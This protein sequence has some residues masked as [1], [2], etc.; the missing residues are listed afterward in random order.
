MKRTTKSIFALIIVL[1][2][3]VSFCVPTFAEVAA[4]VDTGADGTGAVA[5]PGKGEQHKLSIL[6]LTA[7]TA[8]EY[9][10]RVVPAPCQGR[11][12]TIYKCPVCEDQFADNWV[13]G[14][15]AAH[16]YDEANAEKKDPDC[17]NDGY[18]KYTCKKCGD[19]V[20]EIK[21]ALGHDWS[22]W[23]AYID[24]VKVDSYLCTDKGVTLVREC[25]RP[26][27]DVT[28]SQTVT[29]NQE[30]DIV[31]EWVVYPTCQA[32]GTV[33]YTCANDGCQYEHVIDAFVDKDN[34]PADYHPDL[35]YD[36][37]AEGYIAPTCSTEGLAVNAY[38]KACGA[39]GDFKLPKVAHKW[40]P[41]EE[42]KPTCFEGGYKAHYD[43]EYCDALSLDGS[44][45]EK[46]EN[47]VLDA[48]NHKDKEKIDAESASNS[49]YPGVAPVMKDGTTY[50]PGTLVPMADAVVLK[51]E[52]KGWGMSVYYCKDCDTKYVEYIA[53]EENHPDMGEYIEE[54]SHTEWG[55]KG[56][57]CLECGY[58]DKDT[59]IMLPPY[60]HKVESIDKVPANMELINKVEP[61]C[62][63]KGTYTYECKICKADGVADRY[64][65]LEIP[66]LGHTYVETVVNPTCQKDGW[67]WMICSCGDV[68]KDVEGKNDLDIAT[69]KYNHK[70]KEEYMVEIDYDNLKVENEE[71]YKLLCAFHYTTNTE[72]VVLTAPTCTTKGWSRT[73]CEKCDWFCDRQDVPAL[74]HPQ[75]NWKNVQEIAA[76]CTNPGGTKWTCG[77]CNHNGFTKK[78]DPL[79]HNYYDNADNFDE[80]VGRYFKLDDEGNKV[81]LGYRVSVVAPTCT[82]G[83]YT[84][85][86]CGRCGDEAQFLPK[87]KLGHSWE[88]EDFVATKPDPSK[89]EYSYVEYP[90]CTYLDGAADGVKN[91]SW[92]YVCQNA[93]CPDK[94]T[95]KALK[96]VAITDKNDEDYDFDFHNPKHHPN[97]TNK[98][99]SGNVL[100]FKAP[101]CTTT[102]IEKYY[103]AD[104]HNRYGETS[105]E[106]DVTSGTFDVVVPKY[107]CEDHKINVV[108]RVEATCFAAGNY[109][110]FECEKCGTKY[111][112]DNAGTLVP[113][114]DAAVLVIPQR[115]HKYGREDNCKEDNPCIQPG[116]TYEK[117]ALAH[118]LTSVEAKE[119]TCTAIGWYAYSY[120]TKC[121]KTTYAERDKLAHTVVAGTPVLATCTEPG[122]TYFACTTCD[123][124]DYI[125]FYNPAKGHVYNEDPDQVIDATCT[126]DG[127]EI[128]HCTVCNPTGVD[129]AETDKIVVIPNKYNYVH[130]NADG[131]PFDFTCVN[132]IDDYFCVQCNATIAVTHGNEITIYDSVDCKEYIYEISMCSVCNLVTS[133]RTYQND[134]H[135]WGA[136]TQTVA[137]TLTSEGEEKRK[138]QIC[139]QYDEPRSVPA[140]VGVGFD[141]EIT[142]LVGA[143]ET[144][145]Y[146]GRVMLVI[147]MTASA[148]I[149]ANN[150]IVN[151]GFDKDLVNFVGGKLLSEDFTPKAEDDS[152]F[153]STFTSLEAAN[154]NGYVVVTAA[155]LAGDVELTGGEFAV[156]YFDISVTNDAAVGQ[157]ADFVVNTTTTDGSAPSA[158][159]NEAKDNIT[160]LYSDIDSVL[161]AR[162]GNLTIG[163]DDKVDGNDASALLAILKAKY[164]G[165]AY[166]YRSEADLDRDG[167]IT[168]EDYMIMALL[169]NGSVVYKD[170]DDHAVAP[171]I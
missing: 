153:V 3:C 90:T 106:Y 30:H 95:E 29:P 11:G 67:T 156:L 10:V 58:F 8:A 169:N 150:V 48:I 136:W 17:L 40:N 96:K 91:G 154:Q 151:I 52:N 89:P 23:A 162:A 133:Q 19:V 164:D 146:A 104:C 138:C 69:G 166:T 6:G 120:C 149:K 13:D 83:G 145:G 171:K 143:V 66:A 122:Y 2:M 130:K 65:T 42:K 32:K 78:A 4:V 45:E 37:N 126:A 86:A 109:E 15:D 25:K 79:G 70:T 121:G 134:E 108:Q 170:L 44:T 82:D 72:K 80:T 22:E 5:C 161:V 105:G 160:E 158:V 102:G 43:C 142:N 50:V 33:K 20:T 163:L 139:A 46:R 54:P 135:T 99:A 41:V 9:V 127:K 53:P 144:D 36:V 38:C 114:T 47:V 1:V 14:E 119:P 98:D 168:A 73:F 110:S 59:M 140:V 115:E 64:T 157:Y 137:P 81:Y 24:G 31:M 147:D 74:N 155:S 131:L 132:G 12:F 71:D 28:E 56:V 84:V 68:K 159:T 57:I 92:V 103:C 128:Y 97:A 100:Y 112:Y 51:D 35:V 27:C 85:I 124:Q 129:N 26:D 167:D 61:Q 34:L 116:C 63:T 21:P 76:D 148:G 94:G 16:D 62:G 165:K 111:F 123:T 107:N 152:K 60:T 77:I 7:E 118:T 88:A 39:T 101:T 49:C 18:V 55:F 113:Y 117:P 125:D 87:A 93:N 75:A 141:F